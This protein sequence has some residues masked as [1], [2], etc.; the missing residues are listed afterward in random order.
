MQRVFSVN[1]LCTAADAQLAGR[2]SGHISHDNFIAT[3]STK[4]VNVQDHKDEIMR[5]E[6]SLYAI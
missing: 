1:C 4:D 5:T 3:R 2:W 6:V